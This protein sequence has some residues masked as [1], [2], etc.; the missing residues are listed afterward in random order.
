MDELDSHFD[1]ELA[2]ACAEL[3]LVGL[4]L[5]EELVDIE[6]GVLLPMVEIIGLGLLTIPVL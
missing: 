1:I 6:L 2:A 4:G 3:A 5:V